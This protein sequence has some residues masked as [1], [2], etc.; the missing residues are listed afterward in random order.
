MRKNKGK[1]LRSQDALQKIASHWLSDAFSPR[2]EGVEPRLLS[3]SSDTADAGARRPCPRGMPWSC[4]YVEGESFEIGL[5]LGFEMDGE[6]GLPATCNT[7]VIFRGR[8]QVTRAAS[9]SCSKSENSN[10]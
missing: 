9:C 8:R 7:R 1:A 5:Q 6:T 2:G 3:Q 10:G 4:P